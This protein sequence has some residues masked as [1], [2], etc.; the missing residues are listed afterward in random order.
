MAKQ[1]LLRVDCY[2]EEDKVI[3]KVLVLQKPLT[4][5]TPS[6]SALVLKSCLE[7]SRPLGSGKHEV[8]NRTGDDRAGDNLPTNPRTRLREQDFGLRRRLHFQ[9]FSQE[10]KLYRVSALTLHWKL[11]CIRISPSSV[12]KEIPEYMSPTNRVNHPSRA[13]PK[14]NLPRLLT[15]LPCL[16]PTSQQ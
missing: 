7:G 1:L 4:S 5:L 15:H 14:G 16:S 9:P 3:I 11:Q 8:E 6:D 12:R 10:A 13:L 2:G